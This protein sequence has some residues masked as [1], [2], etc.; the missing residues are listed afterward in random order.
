MLRF[1][2][3]LS[4]IAIILSMARR[5]RYGS[6]GNGLI[7]RLVGIALLAAAITAVLIFLPV[8]RCL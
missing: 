7:L 1:A 2:C 3:L 6:E 5:F 4:G 8:K